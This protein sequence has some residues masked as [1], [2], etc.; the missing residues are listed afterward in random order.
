MLCSVKDSKLSYEK[1]WFSGKSMKKA[2][3]QENKNKPEYK[4]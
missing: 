2:A 1:H 4:R 3:E